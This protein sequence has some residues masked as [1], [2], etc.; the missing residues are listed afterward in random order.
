V[1]SAALATACGTEAPGAEAPG[2]ESPTPITVVDSRGK[3]IRF[4]TVPERIFTTSY[5]HIVD[6]LILLE[7]PPFAY[8]AYEEEA[9]PEW[10]RAAIDEAGYEIEPFVTV[11]GDAVNYEALAALRPDVIIA[12]GYEEDAFAELEAIAPLV[13]VGTEGFDLDGSRLRILGELVGRPE[14]AEVIVDDLLGGFDEVDAPS[15]EMALVFGF[16][17]AS[18]PRFAVEW[19]DVPGREGEL[20]GELGFDVKSDWPFDRNEFGYAEIS[21]ENFGLLDEADFVVNI[22][23]YPGNWDD[24]K[25]AIEASPVMQ[26]LEVYQRGEVF[27]LTPNE[28]QAIVQWTPLATPTLVDI[29]ER[30]T[31]A[32]AR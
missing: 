7:E 16:A 26:N 2:A 31:E 20:M 32:R 14:A 25:A 28:S 15:D 21:E 8:G 6:E 4:D 5:R 22:G 3:T 1:T 24:D 29:V 30:I 12:S 17:D 10:T 18:G 23:P 19:G 11:Y 27:F 9:L 13:V